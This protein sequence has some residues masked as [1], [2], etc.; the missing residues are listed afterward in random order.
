MFPVNIKG[1]G[2]FAGKAAK[3][4]MASISQY[5]DPGKPRT[6]TLNSL[7]SSMSQSKSLYCNE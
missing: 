4:R 1:G 7:Y 2:A 6:S 5:L 3:P